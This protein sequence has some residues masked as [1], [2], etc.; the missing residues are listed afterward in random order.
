MQ[1]VIVAG[2]RTFTDYALLERK[3]DAV[4]TRLGS[5]IVIVS[6]RSKGA[7]QLGERYAKERSLYCVYVP[8]LWNVHGRAAGPMRNR[9]ML[10]IA[11]HVVVFWDGESK[12]AKDLIEEAEKRGL[13]LRVIRV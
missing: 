2:T 8:A 11:T 9:A 3:L 12:G 13:P 5:D 10:K 1:F 7:D 4:L 6:G